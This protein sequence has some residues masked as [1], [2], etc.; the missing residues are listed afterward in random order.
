MV[1]SSNPQLSSES[2]FAGLTQNGYEL[3]M[4]DPPW[5]FTTWSS[6]GRGRSA[7]RHYDTMTLQDIASL[8]VTELA[9]PNCLLWLWGTH[10]MWPQA[11][12][13]MDAWG[14]QYKTHGVWVKRTARG[15]LGFGTGYIL[16][17]ASEPFLIGT[18]GKPKNARTVRTVIEGLLREHSRKPDEAYNAAEA[19]M[20]HARRLE[21][22]SR[23]TRPGW[24]A[25]GHEAGKFDGD[26]DTPKLDGV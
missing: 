1:T 10:P 19:L 21:L 12:A 23:E 25:W 26:R 7:D 13:V 6:K 2:T 15:R 11:K 16:R 8:P 20:P 9:A 5:R 14:F 3:I 24:D 18:L 22:F 4:A 17:S